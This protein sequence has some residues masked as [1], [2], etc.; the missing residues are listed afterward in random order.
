MTTYYNSEYVELSEYEL[1]SMFHDHLDS[2][3]PPYTIAW[4]T[5]SPSE[6]VKASGQDS[7]SYRQLYV[8]WLDSMI[9]LG[10]LFEGEGEFIDQLLGDW[11]IGDGWSDAWI[12]VDPTDL[13]YAV[14]HMHSTG[15]LELVDGE[16]QPQPH[17]TISTI[18][19]LINDEL[20][21]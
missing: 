12:D 18:Q 4:E 10:E 15:R 6:I 11:L 7:T 3:Y 21:R 5:Y 9:D 8:A 17:H 20:A 19:A 13:L 1:H 2:D 14:Q 16:I